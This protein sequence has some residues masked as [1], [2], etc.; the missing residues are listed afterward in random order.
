MIRTAFTLVLAV[1]LSLL[2]P[3]PGGLGASAEALSRTEV[4]RVSDATTWQDGD[5]EPRMAAE[6]FMLAMA[7]AD[8]EA[9]W[10][11]ASEED[12]DAFGTQA[13]VYQAFAETFPVLVSVA[14]L[15]FETIRQ[16]GEMSSVRVSLTDKSGE[17]HNGFIG[18]WLDDA[19][20]WKLV[21][22][23]VQPSPKHIAAL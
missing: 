2:S 8:A 7:N 10:A 3:L 12:Q 16:E 23:D 17:H 5:V 14:E 9:V 11:Y 1:A 18:L 13:A 6:A 21:S 22:C 4:V 19:G 20:S 15:R